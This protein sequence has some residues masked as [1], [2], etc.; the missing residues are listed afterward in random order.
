M[1]RPPPW[2]L[3]TSEQFIETHCMLYCCMYYTVGGRDAHKLMRECYWFCKTIQVYKDVHSERRKDQR[4][5][6]LEPGAS[7]RGDQVCTLLCTWCFSPNTTYSTYM[8]Y[9]HR[10]WCIVGMPFACLCQHTFIQFCKLIKFISCYCCLWDKEKILK[11]T[12]VWLK[13]KDWQIVTNHNLG[14]ISI[15]FSFEAHIS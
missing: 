2:Q 9:K 7:G 13:E 6:I 5:H 15:V 1:T 8:T 12:W 11:I 4:A 3:H 14:R 10:K